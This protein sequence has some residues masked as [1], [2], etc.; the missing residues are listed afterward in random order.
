DYD[1]SGSLA[2]RF[3]NSRFRFFEECL[4]RLG[5]RELTVLDVGGNE[6]FWMARGYIGHPRIR[7]TLLNLR[8]ETTHYPNLRSIAGDACDMRI[9]SD[10]EF[11]VGF[12]NSA[13]EHLATFTPQQA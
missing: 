2:N 5:D 6:H 13:I 10:G 8:K 1:N 9:F 4:K 3:R 7:I 12:S 11:D